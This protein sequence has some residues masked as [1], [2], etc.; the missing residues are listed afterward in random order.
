MFVLV[1]LGIAGV[2]AALIVVAAVS[3]YRATATA[4][5]QLARHGSGD[6]TPWWYVGGRVKFTLLAGALGCVTGTALLVADGPGIQ[7]LLAG[8]GV[9]TLGTLLLIA[10][11]LT[12]H[13]LRR[14]TR[15]SSP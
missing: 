4:Y 14:N 3:D 13:Q 7:R 6:R 15:R 11:E 10:G 2:V 1:A 8:A 5:R 9:L 12:G